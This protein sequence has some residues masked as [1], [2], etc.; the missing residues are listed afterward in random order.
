MGER[1]KHWEGRGEWLPICVTR[2]EISAGVESG[3]WESAN[4]SRE[5]NVLSKKRSASDSG[6]VCQFERENTHSHAA[7]AGV[8][9]CDTIGEIT[10]IPSL[11]HSRN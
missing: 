10:L 6:S 4:G 5:W 3:G 9:D 1:G 11:T 7:L 2:M 8:I